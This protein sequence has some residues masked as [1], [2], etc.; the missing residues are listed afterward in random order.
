[1]KNIAEEWI[2]LGNLEKQRIYF[3]DKIISEDKREKGNIYVSGCWLERQNQIYYFKTRQKNLLRQFILHELLGEK[4]SEFFGLQ[5]VHYRL[6]SGVIKGKE[7]IGLLSKWEREETSKYIN[8]QNFL[9]RNSFQVFKDLEVLDRVRED[10]GNSPL[11]LEMIAFFVREY[12]TNETDRI[13]SEIL[14]EKKEREVH[15]GYLCDYESEFEN[16]NDYN[17]NYVPGLY[18]LNLRSN[19]MIN[20][21][22]KEKKLLLEFEKALTISLKDM[23]EEIEQI[24]Q[25]N[26]NLKEVNEILDF[27]A[28]RKN[29]IELRLF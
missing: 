28:K 6:A 20:K 21:I 7:V 2:E 26:L 1:M 13:A 5:T 27:E 15:L 29:Q 25:L 10:Y 23:L 8:L 19:D 17:T 22:K 3:N 11:F 24:H 18:S 16:P 9:N 14:I 4:V 12:F